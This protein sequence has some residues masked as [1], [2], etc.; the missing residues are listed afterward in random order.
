[1]G[2]WVVQQGDAIEAM[3]MIRVRWG[4]VAGAS[5][6]PL[7][8]HTTA[9]PP[10]LYTHTTQD[11]QVEI[12]QDRRAAEDVRV[13]DSDLDEEV[14]EDDD[15]AVDSRSSSHTTAG[16]GA[17]AADPMTA[18]PSKRSIMWQARVGTA[19]LSSSVTSRDSVGMGGMLGDGHIDTTLRTIPSV[20]V[21]S[22]DAEAPQPSGSLYRPSPLFRVSMGGSV[23]EEPNDAV[24][25]VRSAGEF[26]L[27]SVWGSNTVRG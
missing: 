13:S 19:G 17:D 26:L 6:P 25:S 11:G 27:G 10:P 15:A 4:V 9:H 5:L 14:S 22:T 2:A 23:A 1:M 21:A 12:W 20:S 8:T 3:Y 18:L 16:T 7:H 24:V